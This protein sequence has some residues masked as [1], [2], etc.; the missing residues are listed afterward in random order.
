MR[1]RTAVGLTVLALAVAILSAAVKLGNFTNVA[2]AWGLVASAI[3]LTLLAAGFWIWPYLRRIVVRW[4]IRILPAHFAS[5]HIYTVDKLE[6]EFIRFRDAFED[7]DG[8]FHICCAKCTIST[9]RLY[10]KECATLLAWVRIHT[11]W[12][13]L[14]QTSI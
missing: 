2:I 10:E 6:A 7:A 9:R 4:P 5:E 1:N 3:L 11:A 14:W 13:E 8:S 12:N